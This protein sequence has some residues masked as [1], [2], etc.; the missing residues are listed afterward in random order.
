YPS[1]MSLINQLSEQLSGPALQ[2]LSQQI[3]ADENSTQSAISAALPMMMGAMAKN[4]NSSEG[5]SG[6][7]S[8]LDMDGDGSI[9]DDLS[10][11]LGSTENGPAA[12]ILSNLFGGQQSNVERGVS[13]AAGLDMGQTSQLISN[14]APVVM[15]FLNKQKQEQGFDAGGLQNMLQQERGMMQQ[16]AQEGNSIM[17]MANRFLDADGDGSAIDDI[18]GKLF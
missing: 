3:G 12:S 5:A 15:S 14:L 8:M 9:M 6:L 13:Q 7:M 17:D 16:Q 11:F 10:G 18:L 4:A 2:A 1:I